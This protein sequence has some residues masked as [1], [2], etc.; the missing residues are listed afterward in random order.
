MSADFFSIALV[1]DPAAA[2]RAV[3]DLAQLET[4]HRDNVYLD[5]SPDALEVFGVEL[6]E[7]MFA[8]SPNLPAFVAI[9][10]FGC[11]R[12]R[13]AGRAIRH[14]PNA[15]IAAWRP[16]W[17]AMRDAPGLVDRVFPHLDGGYNDET[18]VT[19]AVAAIDQALDEAEARCMDVVLV[20]VGRLGERALLRVCGGN[21]ST[22]VAPVPPIHLGI[23]RLP[24]AKFRLLR[25]D[26]A[27]LAAVFRRAAPS[28]QNRNRR[29]RRVATEAYPTAV[30]GRGPRMIGKNEPVHVNEIERDQLSDGARLDDDPLVHT[31]HGILGAVC[32]RIGRRRRRLHLGR[33][34]RR[35]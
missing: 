8:M 31:G 7:S 21:G 25:L 29:V 35:R 11:E 9:D 20:C 3:D 4:S 6:D 2:R 14:I 23:E 18:D 16:Q 10:R 13:L 30:H 34:G 17:E 27:N 15:E 24:A 1:V 26:D 32:P 5:C 33:S 28:A 19:A 22:K 12:A